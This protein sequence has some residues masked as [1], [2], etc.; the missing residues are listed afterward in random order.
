MSSVHVSTHPLVLHN[1]ATLRDVTTEPPM[2][3]CALRDLARLLFVEATA[4][5]K[6]TP[7][8]HADA[9][10]RLSDSERSISVLA[11]C[12]FCGPV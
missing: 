8:M 4:E 9:A 10:G 2:F 3:R 6:T 11:W 1:L 5:L 12:R 7:M